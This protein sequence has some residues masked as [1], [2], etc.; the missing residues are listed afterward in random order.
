MSRCQNC[1][2]PY[3]QA[4]LYQTDGQM[5]CEN[6]IT[7]RTIVPSDDEGGVS[8]MNW[9]DGP[10]TSHMLYAPHTAPSDATTIDVPREEYA[11]DDSD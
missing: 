7:S 10:H 9:H 3:D 6:C 5:L 11:D 1:A 2:F 8:M 4:D